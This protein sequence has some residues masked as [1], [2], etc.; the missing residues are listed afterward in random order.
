VCAELQ[1]ADANER[2]AGAELDDGLTT[3][4]LKLA[5]AAAGSAA[6]AAVVVRRR[7]RRVVVCEVPRDDARAFRRAAPGVDERLLEFEALLQRLVMT[8]FTKAFVGG[9]NSSGVEFSSR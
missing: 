8:L 6:V 7:R 1:A 3:H 5:N 4:A 2:S 9:A